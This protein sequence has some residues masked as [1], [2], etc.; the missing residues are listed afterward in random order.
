MGIGLGDTSL[1]RNDHMMVPTA[2]PLT[3]PDDRCISTTFP[4][5]GSTNNS[6]FADEWDALLNDPIALDNIG[7]LA[8]TIDDNNHI[9]NNNDPT[10]CSPYI[11]TPPGQPAFSN[12]NVASS[13]SSTFPTYPPNQ[14]HG[15]PINYAIDTTTSTNRPFSFPTTTQ[16]ATSSLTSGVHGPS[17]LGIDTSMHAY[18]AN[19]AFPPAPPPSITSPFDTISNPFSPH[20]STPGTST[21]PTY[22]PHQ[23]SPLVD[24]NALHHQQQT[25]LNQHHHQHHQ[26]R[27]SFGWLLNQLPLADSHYHPANRRHS[28]IASSSAQSPTTGFH[29]A[30]YLTN[31]HNESPGVHSPTSSYYSSRPHT[32]SNLN[33]NVSASAYS[34]NN[35][36]TFSPAL[37]VHH[38]QDPFDFGQVPPP[39]T[40]PPLGFFPTA[41]ESLSSAQ[42]FH[43]NPDPGAVYE[44][45]LRFQAPPPDE[46]DKP[47]LLPKKQNKYK[48]RAVP[49]PDSPHSVPDPLSSLEKETTIPKDPQILLEPA[50]GNLADKSVAAVTAPVKGGSI[51]REPSPLVEH[52]PRPIQELLQNWDRSPTP[53]PLLTGPPYRVRTESPESLKRLEIRRGKIIVR[54]GSLIGLGLGFSPKEEEI[55]ETI[56]CPCDPLGLSKQDCWRKGSSS[57]GSRTRNTSREGL[58]GGDDEMNPISGVVAGVKRKS[59]DSGKGKSKELQSIRPGVNTMLGKSVL[60]LPPGQT[61]AQ[62][63]VHAPKRKKP[64]IALSCAQCTKRKQKCNRQ[65]PCQHCTCEWALGLH[66]ISH[67]DLIL[68]LL[69]SPAA[70]RVNSLAIGLLV[71]SAKADATFDLLLVKIRFLNNVCVLLGSDTHSHDSQLLLRIFRYH[72]YPD[73]HCRKARRPHQHLDPVASQRKVLKSRRK[74]R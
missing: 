15:D 63:V 13:T 20:P 1:A 35:P 68:T 22:I 64:R 43:I 10:L 59:D 7:L 69:I 71:P 40:A 5:A 12:T 29:F 58:E 37:S 65:I 25:H 50:S 8:A 24:L 33:P 31:H 62:Q 51:E 14:Y 52:K 32:H 61:P 16:L 42:P 72:I 60:E 4:D 55:E 46:I 56:G 74:K 18:G 6:A 27:R 54:G 66:C 44:P 9:N 21:F 19:S 17:P 47:V 2:F 38:D 23:Q 41:P 45:D 11:P 49:Q 67:C 36:P 70:R 57:G 48:K 39:R 73:N 30:P 3:R 26:Q 34:N 53:P 28:H